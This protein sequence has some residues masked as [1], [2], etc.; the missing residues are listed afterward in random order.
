MAFLVG[1]DVDER[2]TMIKNVDEFYGIRSALIH[3][4]KDVQDHQKDV[5]DEFFVN[6]WFSFVV[7]M[8]N[9]SAWKTREQMFVDL[10]ERKLS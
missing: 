9:V 4:G 7:L 3:H 8:R 2:R 5:V 6:I 10:E 1:H